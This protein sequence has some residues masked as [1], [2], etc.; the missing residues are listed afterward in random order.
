MPYDIEW[1]FYMW[2]VSYKVMYYFALYYFDFWPSLL[3]SAAYLVLQLVIK[4]VVYED[5]ID[6]ETAIQIIPW[7]SYC[8][9]FCIIMHMIVNKVGLLYVEA[10]IIRTGNEQLLNDLDQGVIIIKEKA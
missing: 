5:P 4:R 7:L 9:L 6:F 10:E 8:L 2:G 3:C 1:D